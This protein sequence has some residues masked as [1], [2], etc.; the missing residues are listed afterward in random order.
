MIP[1]LAALPAPLRASSPLLA[2]LPCPSLR[3]ASSSSPSNPPRPP[4]APTKPR[5]LPATSPSHLTP[6]EASSKAT[7]TS[8]LPPSPA[9]PLAR[10]LGIP[11]PPT[12]RKLTTAEWRASLLDQNSRMVER[13][14]L[15]KQI[16]SGYFKDYHELRKEGGKGWIA[17]GTLIREDVS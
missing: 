3:R 12:T 9:L 1:R 5:P 8:L 17:P 2:R 15:V 13:K 10:A 6:S 4:V 14:H 16:A 7:E 11:N